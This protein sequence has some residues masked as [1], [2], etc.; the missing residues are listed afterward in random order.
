MIRLN[1]GC[2]Q[3]KKDGYVNLDKYDSFAP[4]IVW[5]LECVPW[6]FEASVTLGDCVTPIIGRL[7]LSGSLMFC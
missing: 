5:D 1:L 4:D 7:G 6:P 3:F 2:G